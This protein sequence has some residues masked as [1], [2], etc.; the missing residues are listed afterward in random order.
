MR[1]HTVDTF[2]RELLSQAMV[3]DPE[4][5]IGFEDFSRALEDCIN[6]TKN[7]VRK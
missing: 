1:S 4:K 5:R 3:K 7:R 6:K 2:Y